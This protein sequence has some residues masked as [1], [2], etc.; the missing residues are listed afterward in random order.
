MGFALTSLGLLVLTL[1]IT[2]YTNI[3]IEDY[4]DYTAMYEAIAGYGLGG[5][6]IPFSEELVEVFSLKLLMSELI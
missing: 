4:E 6:T 3:F 2:L 1:L 5:S